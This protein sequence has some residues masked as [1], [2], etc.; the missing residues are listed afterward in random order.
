MLEK[1][2]KI[3]RFVKSCMNNTYSSGAKVNIEREQYESNSL[4]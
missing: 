4:L 2:L 3:D 1:D